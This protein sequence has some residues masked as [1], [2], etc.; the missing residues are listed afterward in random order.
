MASPYRK[1]YDD[2]AQ[3][4]SEYKDIVIS[5]LK[6]S[7]FELHQNEQECDKLNLRLTNLNHRLNGLQNEKDLDEKEY[8]HRNDLNTKTIYNLRDEVR[9]LEAELDKIEADIAL[10]RNDND[11]VNRIISIKSSDLAK[12]KCELADLADDN[13]ALT[14]DN[15]DLEQQVGFI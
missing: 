10:K 1:R 5:K 12:L 13:K 15:K 8:N 9:A 14:L 7:A 3:Q 11:G 6:A 2:L 4:E